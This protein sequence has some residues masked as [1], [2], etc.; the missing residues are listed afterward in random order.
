MRRLATT[1][2][3]FLGLLLVLGL[4]AMS[5]EVRPVF[6]TGANFKTILIQTAIVAVG[7]LGMTMIIVTAGIDLSVGSVVALGSV[8]AAKGLNAGWP[9]VFVGAVVVLLG[10]A[11]GAVNGTLVS[12]LRLSPFIVT[13]GGMGMI[14]GAAKW[15]ADKQ[16][17]PNPPDAILGALLDPR[18][19]ESFFPLPPGVW[20][21]L[22]LA[23]ATA[24]LMRQTVFGRRLFAIGS[25]E[26][27]ARLSG[28][29]IAWVKTGVYAVAGLLFGFAGLLQNARLSLGDPTA[30]V[31]LELDIIAAVVIGGASLSGGVGSVLGS[32]VGALTMAVL[33]SGA[34]QIGWE[35]Y[36]Q[37]MIIGA[38]I[39]VAVGL[40]Q[41]R[42]SRAK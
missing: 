38:V 5:S 24:V 26:A 14:R 27:A 40:D 2:G 11:I 4:I 31:G 18:R 28:V 16:T 23:V 33:R 22:A 15:A 12:R 34:N 6:F 1:A 9:T 32:M 21:A 30:A 20:T 13:L 8:A 3:P 35:T 41:W 37:E 10:G 42:Q 7:A 17:V 36:I 29:P 39:V 25:N 19:P